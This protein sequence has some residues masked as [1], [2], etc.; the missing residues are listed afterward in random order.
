MI[1]Y[2][3]TIITNEDGKMKNARGRLE[4]L[5]DVLHAHKAQSEA[6][7]KKLDV[8]LAKIDAEIARLQEVPVQKSKKLNEVLKAS[9]QRQISRLLSERRQV[10]AKEGPMHKKHEALKASDLKQIHEAELLVNSQMPIGY[11]APNAS[12]ALQM[13][14]ELPQVSAANGLIDSSVLNGIALVMI[15]SA[16][17]LYRHVKVIKVPTDALINTA[18]GLG[19]SMYSMFKHQA[20]LV[21]VSAA[22]QADQKKSVDNRPRV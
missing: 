9:N 22:I 3:A 12:I 10:E 19:G 7:H 14:R 20:P 15:T 17:M 11:L 4:S 5:Q 18:I 16:Y 6:D 1:T 8:E 13:T 21:L 2:G